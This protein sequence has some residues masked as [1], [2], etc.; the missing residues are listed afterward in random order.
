MPAM[1]GADGEQSVNLRIRAEQRRPIAG[2]QPDRQLDAEAA[3]R[4]C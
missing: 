2:R 3:Q 4:A 1:C